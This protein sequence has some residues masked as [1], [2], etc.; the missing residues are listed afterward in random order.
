MKKII[1]LLVI[2]LLLGVVTIANSFTVSP[3]KQVVTL[4]QGSWVNVKIKVRNTERETTKY[5][6]AVL[7]V[8]QDDQG[9]PVYGEGI[10]EAENWV[11]AEQDVLEIKPGKE[12]EATFRV[13][14]PKGTYPGS[15]YVGL[16]AE[17]VL[18]EIES[19]NFSGKLISLLLLEVSGTVTEELSVASWSGEKEFY[20]S[21]EDAKFG[22][23]L[24]NSGN[25]ELPITAKI[26]LYNWL[27]KKIIDSEVHLGGPLLPKTER[28]SSVLLPVQ[29]GWY[30]PG[31]YRAQL[32]LSYGRTGQKLSVQY[33]FW[34]VP[35]GWLVLIGAVI[36]I[37]VWTIIKKIRNK[38]KQQLSF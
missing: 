12:A 5:K 27:D 1:F 9:Y 24:K 11:R 7:G 32:D 17:P 3:I 36:L 35:I 18:G 22:A 2:C 28:K 21:L 33:P 10:E 26:R 6:I 13:S 19:K 20:W 14:V 4:E 25:T 34:Y 30:L 37:V 29:T 31:L 38:K 15:H 8:K 23:V 16:S